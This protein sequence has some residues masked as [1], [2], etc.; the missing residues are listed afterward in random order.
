MDSNEAG[1]RWADI[2]GYEGLY[3]VSDGGDVYSLPRMIIRKAFG[4]KFING[5]Y[6]AKSVCG[7]GYRYVSLNKDGRR[8]NHYV[9]RLVAESFIDNPNKYP[10]V[11]HI[12]GDK[13]DNRVSNLEWVTCAENIQ[14]S[15]DIGLRLNYQK[16]LR[17]LSNEEVVAIR[18]AREVERKTIESIA[19]RYGVSNATIIHIVRKETYK[20]VN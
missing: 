11:N 12:N 18:N 14:H 7:K 20:E 5:R 1:V 6:L 15:F 19:K 4:S 16:R 2:P 13:D 9:H 8:K 3:K 10:Q 17:K